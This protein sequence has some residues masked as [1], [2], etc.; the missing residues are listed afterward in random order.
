[1]TEIE[2]KLS[3]LSCGLWSV[4]CKWSQASVLSAKQGGIVS[5]KYLNGCDMPDRRGY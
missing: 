4:A 1:M 2:L 3:N 5:K